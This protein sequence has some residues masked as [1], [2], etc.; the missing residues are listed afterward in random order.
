M[1][2]VFNSS[3]RSRSEKYPRETDRSKYRTLGWG[4]RSLGVV[5]YE[6][7]P[8]EDVYYREHRSFGVE[9]ELVYLLNK[10]VPG[11]VVI[12]RRGKDV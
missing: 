4:V 6:K 1:T 7:E 9:V 5:K 11:R 10:R 3:L 8:H 2:R 12:W